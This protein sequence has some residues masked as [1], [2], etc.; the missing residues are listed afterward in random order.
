[1]N[2]RSLALLMALSLLVAIVPAEAQNTVSAAPTY[3]GYSKR[4]ELKIA[5][6]KGAL[7]ALKVA[8]DV[9][10]ECAPDLA[11]LRVLDAQGREIPYAVEMPPAPAMASGAGSARA[12]A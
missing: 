7:V 5:P 4:A 6:G 10:A 12:M 8:G 2:A 3:A 9:L 1:M 11:D